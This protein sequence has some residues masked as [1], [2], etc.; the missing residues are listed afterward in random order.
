MLKESKLFK[1]TIALFFAICLALSSVILLVQ[2][3]SAQPLNK[4]A[5]DPEIQADIDSDLPR[6][7]PFAGTSARTLYFDN[8]DA[9]VITTTLHLTGTPT[10]TLTTGAAFDQ[11]ENTTVWE[12]TP[13]I[14]DMV[15]QVLTTDISFG[16]IAYTVVDTDS[17]ESTAVISYIQDITA[18]VSTLESLVGSSMVV[19]SSY[20]ANTLPFTGTVQDEQSG[21][22]LMTIE[23]NAGL[24]QAV[25]HPSGPVVPEAAW[26]Y[27]WEVPSADDVVYTFSFYGTDNLGIAETAQIYTVTVDNVAPAPPIVTAVYSPA[28]TSIV[29]SWNDVARAIGYEI[30]IYQNEQL[31][32]QADTMDLS[33]RLPLT[34]SGMFY[35]KVRAYDRHHNYSD[36]GESNT[37]SRYFV[38]LPVVI[39]PYVVENGNIIVSSSRFAGVTSFIATV[40]LNFTDLHFTSNM[41]PD[42]MKMWLGDASEPGS[43][44]PYSETLQDFPLNDNQPGYQEIYVKFRKGTAET[45]VMVAGVFYI[46]NGDF[47]DGQNSLTN[48]GWNL[49]TSP[50]PLSVSGGKL[51]LGSDMYGCDNV[52][53]G[54]ASASIN[55]NLPSNSSYKLYVQAMVHTYDQLPNPAEAKYDAF[56]IHVGGSVRRY[57][58]PTAP[59]GCSLPRHV[60]VS[61]TRPLSVYQ[62][63]TNISLQ[64]YSRYDTYYNTYTD[65]EAIWIGE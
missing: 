55:L 3:I 59:I 34:S 28:I 10:L 45:P 9:G 35:A 58:N 21:V 13:V 30:E 40:N 15:Y 43:W 47:Q 31:L 54:F 22:N 33:Y 25:L 26:S 41:D 49:A 19:T 20:D 64:N 14:T 38:F 16:S 17:L 36:W 39:S 63:S 8:R 61:E 29:F 52:P 56:E 23:T 53:L 1:P 42:E 27:D 50:L 44:L 46:P 24:Q 12:Q 60:S 6:Y 11:P 62:G 48:A 4:L 57:G 51:R 18:P 5:A 32:E 2:V 65:V 7:D 37:V